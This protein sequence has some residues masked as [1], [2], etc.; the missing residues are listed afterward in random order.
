MVYPEVKLE[1]RESD[2]S[3]ALGGYQYLRY[4]HVR[5]R[6]KHRFSGSVRDRYRFRLT[7]ATPLSPS[8]VSVKGL[9]IPSRQM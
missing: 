8:G 2:S 6:R 3:R 4:R 7:C 5:I 9:W 1:R